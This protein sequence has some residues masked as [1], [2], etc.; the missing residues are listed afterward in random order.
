MLRT[1]T[2][3]VPKVSDLLPTDVLRIVYM[4]WKETSQVYLSL[5]KHV[6]G[7]KLTVTDGRELEELHFILRDF[8]VLLQVGLDENQNSIQ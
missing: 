1:T 4:P 6:A 2:I 8:A 5:D 3:T 7:G